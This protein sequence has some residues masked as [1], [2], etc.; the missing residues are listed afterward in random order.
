MNVNCD[1]ESRGPRREGG[2]V[3]VRRLGSAVA[4]SNNAEVCHGIMELFGAREERRREAGGRTDADDAQAV[5]LIS[6]DSGG[7]D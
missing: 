5:R 4:T 6:R 3:E 1:C 2:R 7:F